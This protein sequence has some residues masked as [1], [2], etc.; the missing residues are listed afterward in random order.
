MKKIINILLVI[1]VF[2]L[3][4]NAQID[5]NNYFTQGS[6]R[7][8]LILAGNATE[9]QVY[10][11][12]IKKEAFWGGPHEHLKDFFDYG[13]Y[14]YEVR[15]K[16]TGQLIF[17]RGFCTLF[18]EWQTTNEAKQVNRSFEQTVTFPYPIEAI[19]FL[20]KARKRDGKFEELF[21]MDIDPANYFISPERDAVEVRKIFGE[22]APESSVDLAFIA[23]GYTQEEMAKFLNDVKEMAD[24]IL[25]QTPFNKFRDRFNIWAVLSPSADSGV[26]IPGEKIYKKTAVNSSFY[27]FDSERY[28]TTE[29]IKSTR[30][31]AANVPYDAILILANEKKYGGG[32]IYN[33]YAISTVDH[34]LSKKVL[35]HEFGHSFAGLGDEYY[36]SSVSYNDY[37]NLEIEPWQPN[38]TTMVDFEKKWKN[39]IKPETPIPTPR[40]EQFENT[41]GVF[42][43]GGYVARGIYSPVM[44]CRMKSNAAEGFCP[45]CQEAIEEMILFYTE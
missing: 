33:H 2:T 8:D 27:T 35:I 37:Y 17:S 45:V 10:L 29:D 38:I 11:D 25:S 19:S 41:V 18:E 34:R 5:F 32:G 39:M 16:A 7:V 1:F 21:S 14:R 42:E 22:G 4:G 3:S 44:D 26:E 28:L 36:T 15:D 13:E 43:G 23:E 40:E 30:S 24:Y 9:K 12:E 31:L 6:M 20:V